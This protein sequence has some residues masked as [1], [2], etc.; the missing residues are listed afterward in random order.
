MYD[1]MKWKI[2]YTTYGLFIKIFLKSK[3][4]KIF[5]YR[6]TAGNNGLGLRPS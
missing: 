3:N 6:P 5:D 2:K 1:K 4:T